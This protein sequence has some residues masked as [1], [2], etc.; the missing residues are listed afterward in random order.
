MRLKHRETI[1][2]I[3]SCCTFFWKSCYLSYAQMLKYHLISGHHMPKSMSA[4]IALSQS[5]VYHDFTFG[6]L[7][8]SALLKVPV[9]CSKNQRN[10]EGYRLP[11]GKPVVCTDS[12]VSSKILKNSN[13]LVK[14]IYF[15]KPFFWFSTHVV[16]RVILH[17]HV[18]KR[19]CFE[20]IKTHWVL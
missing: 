11:V 15:K 1:T 6:K 17:S 19:H 16:G 7:N 13:L 8:W 9:P 10:H 3:S 5:S 2:V 12:W 14:V 20:N 4:S 18:Q